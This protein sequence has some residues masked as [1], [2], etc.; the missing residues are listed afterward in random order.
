MKK[1][2][3]KNDTY[4][5]RRGGDSKLLNIY[6]RKCRNFICFYQK[7]GHGGLFRLYLDR[8]FELTVPISHKDLM[9][10]EGHLLA[11]AIIYEKENRVAFRLFEHSIIKRLVK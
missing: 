2:I 3:L 6:C 1:I 5:R 11:V 4:R 8:M 10:P 9:C 7:D